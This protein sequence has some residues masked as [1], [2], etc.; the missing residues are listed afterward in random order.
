[1]AY[2]HLPAAKAAEDLKVHPAKGLSLSQ[3]QNRQAHFGRNELIAKRAFNPIILFLR[4][5]KSFIIYILLFALFISLLTGEMAETIVIGI[6]LILNAIIGFFQEFKAE[7]AIEALSQ[8]SIQKVRAIR[9]GNEQMVDAKDLVPGDIIFLEEGNKVPADGRILETLNL[10]VSEASLTGESMGVMKQS[11]PLKGGLPI[12][13]QS[14]M[15]FAGTTVESGRAKVLI[16]GTGMKTELGKIAGMITS[17]ERKP[18]PLQEKLNVLGKWIGLVII[19]ICIIVFIAG[20]TKDGLLPILLSG[21]LI[22]FIIAAREW[23]LI[24]V[25][26]AVAAV[27]GGLPAIVTIALALGVKSMV[28]RHALIRRL[29]SV[30]TLGEA[31]VICTDKTGTLTEN[32]M[33]V[34]HAYTNMHDFAL[35]GEGYSPDG[36]LVTHD[37]HAPTEHDMLLFRLGSLC[38]DASLIQEG[39]DWHVMGDP[40]EG[41]LIV[42]AQKVGIKTKQLMRSWPRVGG[43]PFDATRKMMST[44]HKVDGTGKQWVVVKGAPE[45]IIKNCERIIIDGRTRKLTAKDRRL[46]LSKNEEMAKKALRVLAFAYKEHKGRTVHEDHLIFV[47]LQGM[48]DPPHPEVND[49]IQRC[50]RAG[51]RVFM[52]TGD[53]RNTAEAIGAEVGI[54]GKVMNGKDF[55]LLDE[56]EQRE[57]LKDT[58]IFARVEPAHKLRIVELLQK[59]GEIVVMTGDGVNDAPAL[60]RADL[61]VAMGIAGTDVAKEVSDMVILDDNFTSIVN[62]IEEGRG[63]D[64]NIKKF[65]NYLLSGNIAEVLVIFFSIL[66]GWPLPMTAIMLIWLNLVTDGM[67]ALALSVD[68]NPNDLMHRPPRHPHEGILTKSLAF[69]IGS[70]SV[71]ITFAMLGMFWW[72]MWRYDYQ[73]AEQTLIHIQSIAFTGIVVMEIVRLYAIRRGFKLGMFSNPWLVLAVLSSVILQLIVLYTPLNQYFNTFPLTITDWLVIVAMSLLVFGLNL[74]LD[75]IRKRWHL[76]QTGS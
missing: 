18:T 71:L 66:L 40:T 14:N 59:S 36:E 6:A 4:Q 35:T 28:R 39:S 50:K 2:Y 46:L 12:A 73:G 52:I 11:K 42:S 55:E 61:G 68:P 34:R 75:G 21:D 15:T 30:E 25:A 63:I 53:N 47:G 69:N 31:T 22:G 43:K 16:T 19:T 67:P 33:T 64:I 29:P 44:L 8:L 26:L 54:V 17:M 70:V 37:K 48:I 38:N 3:V 27:P 7:R 24:S 65:V 76:F 57:A 51:I 60:K 1:M 13:D 5:F 56:A 10:K 20:I 58:F 32:A 45:Q 72:G 23:F 49:A 41:A 9:D 62:A 74:V